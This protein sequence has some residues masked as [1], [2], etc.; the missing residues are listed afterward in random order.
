MSFERVYLTYNGN[1]RG[2]KA[3]FQKI[4]E[5]RP[6]AVV[7]L[8]D[9]ISMGSQNSTWH[10]VDQFVKS[11]N[12]Q[13]IG[14]SPIPG[15]HEYLLS[16][17][18][19]IAHFTSRYPGANLTG[20]SREY[21]NVAVVLV[22]SNFSELSENE[23]QGQLRWYRKTLEDYENKPS[24]DFVVVGCHHPPYTNSRIVGISKE[25]RDDY[26]A[27][28]YQAKKCKLFVSGHA[29]AYEHFKINGKDFLVIGGGGGIQHP[30]RIGEK[31]EYKD[32][33]SNSLEK[34]VFHFLTI[35]STDD[36]LSVDLRMLK[37]DF[38]DFENLPQL[39]F[40]R[41]KPRAGKPME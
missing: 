21:G 20:Y 19:G 29:H 30:L 5:I 22:N 38:K 23:R 8:G 14:F 4:L 40:V 32:I 24:I 39:I 2:R 9:Q 6:M 27:E 35:R 7:H 37:P 18:A 28:F 13:G 3:I 1:A 41:V 10:D 15:N 17:K 34:R 33:F 11:L 16:S 12:E 36:T 31:A 25:I 26:L